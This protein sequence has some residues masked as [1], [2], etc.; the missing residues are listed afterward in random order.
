MPHNGELQA[1]LAGVM[2]LLLAARRAVSDA[3]ETGP[4]TITFER[5][6]F[7][8]IVSGLEE[9]ATVV[10]AFVLEAALEANSPPAARPPVGRLAVP[11]V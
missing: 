11:P 2:A 1:M 10:E 7:G 6:E 8:Q 4:I 9:L 5:D 3:E